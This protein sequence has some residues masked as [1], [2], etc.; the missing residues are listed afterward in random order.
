MVN[1]TLWVLQSLLALVFLAHGWLLLSPPANMVEQM[2]ASI[3]PAL[4]IFIGVAEVMAAV[5]LTVPGITRRLPWLVS[6]AAA[7]LAVVMISA[8][9][10]HIMRDE[11][12]SAAVT[13]VLL[14]LVSFV[15]YMRWRVVPFLPRTAA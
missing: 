2:N 15:A 9:I 11:V 3:A 14:A 13:T 4:R 6:A 12:S 10:F 8:T 1:V 5:G 7:G